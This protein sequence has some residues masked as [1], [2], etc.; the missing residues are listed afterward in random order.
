MNLD[1]ILDGSPTF[2]Q[3]ILRLIFVGLSVLAGT[4]CFYLAARMCI[5]QSQGLREGRPLFGPVVAH[6]LI[7]YFFLR[8]AGFSTDVIELL[9]GAAPQQPSSALSY[10][11]AQI[12]Q[13]NFWKRVALALVS[14]VAM[15]GG[16]AIFRGLLLWREMSN[17]NPNQN[18][19][20]M[21]RGL[22]HIVFGGIA[23]N[24]GGLWGS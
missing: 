19:D 4:C 16:I 1:A 3:G 21:W 2:T 13:S 18:G 23:L 14:W 12:S 5:A 6:V 15:F 9:F 11:P 22:W 10:L 24:I 17:G 20:L 8:L 7:G